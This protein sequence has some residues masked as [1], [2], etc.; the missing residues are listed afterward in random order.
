MIRQRSDRDIDNALEAWMHDVAPETVPVPVLEEAFA[1]TMSSPQVR[2]YPW[3]KIPGRGQRA[4][5]QTRLAL[6]GTLAV[7]VALV[8]FGSLGG[9][10]G[11]APVPSP[12]ASPSPTPTPFFSPFPPT[13]SPSPFPATP[14]VPTA[15]VATISPQSLATDGKAL[16]MLT[17][18]GAVERIDTATNTVGPG[19][20]TG[21]TTDLYNG[22]AVDANGVWVTD[23]DSKMLY[24]VDPTTSKVTAIPAGLAPKGVLATGSAVWVADTHDGKV[25]RI[26][27][28]TNKIVATITVGPKGNSGPN[29][30]GSGF[31]SIWTS[32]PNNATIVR[33]DPITN[34]VQDTIKI[35]VEVTPC[36]SF[37][38][39][40]TDVWTQSCGG[41]ATMARIDPATN[42]VAGIIR[43]AG[44]ASAPVVIDGA[45]WVSLD[46]TPVIPGYLARLSSEQ[47]AVDFAL[48]PGPA[49]GGGAD[50]VVAAGSAW[51]IDGANGHILR[52]PLAGFSPS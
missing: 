7:L 42:V 44:V 9:G 22:I 30:L 46:T 28:A 2:L 3:Q 17:S 20:Q 4:G 14:I 13:P 12:S 1:R 11:V 5:T 48:S 40:K 29:W 31:G 33:I 49:F 18:T 15:S 23:W 10:F 27:P 47:D 32:V 26:D 25:F 41:R 21:G 24:R 35:P 6:A 36:G 8:A 50:L 34:T 16:W 52:L 51:T 45:A 37:G 38:F 43:P 19:I 39:T